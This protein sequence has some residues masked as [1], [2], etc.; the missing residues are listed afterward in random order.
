MV[1][2]VVFAAFCVA[3]SVVG[4]SKRENGSLAILHET[5]STEI[6]GVRLSCDVRSTC[7]DP[8][9]D[10]RRAGGVFNPRRE[11]LGR[12]FEVGKIEKGGCG[13]TWSELALPNEKSVGFTMD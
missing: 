3:F 8:V 1:G 6:G 2:E 9:C 4:S 7:S 5:S 10:S 11:R 12:S 13:V